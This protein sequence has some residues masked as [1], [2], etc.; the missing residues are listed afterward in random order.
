MGDSLFV[1][2]CSG[3][4]FAFDKANGDVRWAYDTKIDGARA[5]F[6]GDPVVTDRLIIVGSDVASGEEAEGATIPDGYV[7]AF[8]Q[9]TGDLRWKF[10]LEGGMPS[11]LLR[12]GSSV[13]GVSNDGRLLCLEIGSG[14]LRWSVAPEGGT[15]R[16][17]PRYSLLSFGDKIV[18]SGPEGR[19]TA[20]NPTS[21]KTIWTH[22]LHEE[23]NTTLVRA[24]SDFYVA[25][26]ME[27]IYRL[28][29]K[30]GAIRAQL[31]APGLP[32]GTPIPLDDSLL[33]LLE[34]GDF[35]RIDAREGRVL[36]VRSTE[37]EWSSFRPRVL[38]DRVLVGNAD[39]ELIALDLE[40][41]TPLESYRVHGAVRGFAVADEVLYI[42]TLGGRLFA[43]R[44]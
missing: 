32:Y 40:D 11:D 3:V 34:G 29:S 10:A 1:G 14:K 33:V 41:G 43:R 4:F 23:V 6:H 27:T 20:V 12:I 30:S 18:F 36:W 17:A 31:P 25:T 24:D 15:H 16:H 38:E 21:G 42:G 8:E 9:A 39:G 37:D 35:A 7:Y 2:S 26:D 22:Q 44:M 19:L 13:Y 28:N 5:N